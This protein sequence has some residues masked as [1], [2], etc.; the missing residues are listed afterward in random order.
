MNISQLIG[1]GSSN[2]LYK[3]LNAFTVACNI[4]NVKHYDA[5]SMID[6]K[7]PQLMDK[8][9]IKITVP[10]WCSDNVVRCSQRLGIKLDIRT[11]Y[12]RVHKQN[13]G[14]YAARELAK[15]HDE[16]HLWGFDSLWSDDLTSRMDQKI[17][18]N[19]RPALNRHWHPLWQAIFDEHSHCKFIIH[20]PKG[21][22]CELNAKNLEICEESG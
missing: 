2:T 16:L 9:N 10:V 5:V 18:R 1:N 8:E 22:N 4:P 21:G 19:G 15:T 13:S 11:I 6:D 12:Q 20:K 3:P 7:I 14:H 17:P